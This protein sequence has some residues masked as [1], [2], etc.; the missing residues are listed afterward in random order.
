M[1]GTK[2]VERGTGC[3]SWLYSSVKKNAPGSESVDYEGATHCWDC[4]QLN[5]WK[6]KTF[7]GEQVYTYNQSTT[8]KS[9]EDTLRFLNKLMD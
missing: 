8:K 7:F 2:D 6:K 1:S 5:G 3:N 4:S 9:Q